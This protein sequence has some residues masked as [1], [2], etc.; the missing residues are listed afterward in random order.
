MSAHFMNR[1]IP[2][3]LFLAVGPASALVIRHD[4]E[5][6]DYENYGRETQFDASLNIFENGNA[7]FGA[8]GGSTAIDSRW[9]LHARHTLKTTGDW[10]DAGNVARL[11]GTRWS[12]VS[13]QGLGAVDV[14]QVIHYDD[15]FSRFANAIDIAL[16]QTDA[17]H[18]GLRIAPLYGSFDEV[19]RVGSGA[20]AA[21][22]RNYGNGTSA[23]TR[24]QE[25]SNS[26]RWYEVRWGGKNDINVLTGSSFQGSP[27]NAILKIDFDHPTNT[28]L[29]RFGGNTAIDLEYGYM[30]GDSG[31]PLYVDKNGVIAQVAGVLSGGSGNRY[32]D[33]AVY[34]RVRSFKNWI[35]DT[36]LANP[37]NRTLTLQEIPDQ[38]VDLGES[39]ELSA[40][41]SGSELP[42]QS[43][44]YSLLSPPA[45][46]SIDATTGVIS[47]TPSV[48]VA[49][50]TQTITVQA[51]E[52]GVAANSVTTDFQVIVAGDDVVDFWSWSGGEPAWSEFEG[53]DSYDLA[54]D[55]AYLG[56]SDP[57]VPIYQQ[58]SGTIP[59]WATVSVAIKI[60]DFHQTWAQGGAVEFG[61]YDG[62]PMSDVPDAAFLNSAIANVPNYNGAALED[63]LGNTGGNVDYSL[64][65]DVTEEITD[66]WFT[67][68]K[69]YNGGR[70]GV[71]DVEISYYFLDQDQDGLPNS[72]EASLG[73]DPTLADTDGDGLDDDIEIAANSDPLNSD[74]DSDSDGYAD[75]YEVNVLLSD[76]SDAESPGGPNPLAIGINFNSSNGQ[77]AGV[78]RSL[79]AATYAGIPDVAQKNWNQTEDFALTSLSTQGIGT[80]VGPVAGELV[81]SRGDATSVGVSFT[82]NNSWNIDNEKLT[83]YGSLYAG[84]LDSNATNDASV[85]LTDIPYSSYDIYVYVGAGNVGSTQKITD[86]ETTYS[87]TTAARVT[88]PGVYVQTLNTANGFPSANYAKFSDKSDSS[89][90]VTFLRGSSNGGI[91]AIQIVATEQPTPYENWASERGLDILAEG[92]ESEDPDG[93]GFDNVLEFIL[94]T[95]PEDSGSRQNLT[96]EVGTSSTDVRFVRASDIGDYSAKVMW[97][98]DLISWSDE[99]LLVEENSLS[100]GETEV[101]TTVP[102]GIG[103]KRFF[104]LEVTSP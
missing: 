40:S 19:G 33:E 57:F 29:S 43:V 20:S 41:A 35:T 50:T 54:A 68:R 77:E 87:F 78:A 46:A 96:Y 72:Q 37:D 48:A 65:F 9:G 63:G 67:V 56:G 70:V 92:A 89:V 5:T 73:T 27:S 15:D 38:L 10:L 30:N 3:L 17:A 51:I 88:E 1:L 53:G 103:G 21:N 12:G 18:T 4:T 11:R 82:M 62:E 98:S 84:Y 80:I 74:S 28:S 59:Q 55:F 44:S 75:G 99:G 101:I 83:P 42:P 7:E 34:V 102:G 6:L 16:V 24:A 32:G 71:D 58:I 90:T 22:N 69:N 85:T 26:N 97:S 100:A 61:F 2:S 47:W 95:E 14:N 104:R 79:S 45:G 86:G 52:N 8:L 93:D 25:T 23:K 76:P 66:P 64:L 60:A 39:V 13:F 36:V 31:S 81:D 94:G 91:N 49:D